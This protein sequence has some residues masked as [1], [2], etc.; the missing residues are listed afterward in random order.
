L[1]TLAE[2]FEGTIARRGNQ[3]VKTDGMSV[4]TLAEAGEKQSR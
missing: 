3:K 4:L 2:V 1:I